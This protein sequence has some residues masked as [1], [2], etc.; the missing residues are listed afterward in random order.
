MGAKDFFRRL[1]RLYWLYAKMDAAWIMRD[2]KYCL[3]GIL[4]DFIGNL[5]VLSGVFLMAERFGGVGGMNSDEVLFMLGY[6]AV[7][8]GLFLI[9]VN[10]NNIGNISRIIGRGQMDHKLIQPLPLRLQLLTEGFMPIS[11]SGQL[12]AG[13]A[14]CGVALWRLQYPVTV[15]WIMLFI[16]SHILSKIILL[17][18]M[19]FASSLAFWFP[20]AAEEISTD[21]LDVQWHLSSYPLGQMPMV[22]K[23]ALNTVVPIGLTV[24][25]PSLVLLGKQRLDFG[26][27]I[28]LIAA[29]V[30][31]FCATT[32]FKKGLKHYEK[33]GSQRYKDWGHRR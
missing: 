5:S 31:A 17:S 30:A 28:L 25:L 27:A 32:L 16:L 22:L 26:L 19:Y 20:V 3:I 15:G 23:I 10:G 29:G 6:N 7:T 1:F 33:I 8:T 14:V 24:W 11:G 18:M 2:T 21:V 9:F 12:W 13:L 4:A